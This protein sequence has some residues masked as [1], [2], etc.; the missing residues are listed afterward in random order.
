M[1]AGDAGFLIREAT[2]DDTQGIASV[3]VTAWQETYGPLL[4]E[5][6][7][8]DLDVDARASR[9]AEIISGGKTILV[10]ED[11]PGIVAWATE[12]TGRD[13]DVPVA[14]ELEGIYALTRVHGSGVRQQL[15]DASIGD[16]PAYLWVL[17]GND[18]A[19]AFYRRNGFRRDGA[20][21]EHLLAGHP[22]TTVRMVRG[23]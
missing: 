12:G 8:D 11:A 19:E 1:K 10:A 23:S 7:L 22:R 18:R 17:D 15:L 2:V 6:A 20:E 21:R 13:D 4:P 14:R 9:W 3:H 16:E 5:G